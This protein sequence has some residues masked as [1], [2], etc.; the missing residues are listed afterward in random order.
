LEQQFINFDET[1]MLTL[2]TQ[3]TD[4]TNL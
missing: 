4:E 1:S 3:Q 2:Q